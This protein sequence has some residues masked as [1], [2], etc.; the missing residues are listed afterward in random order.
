[1]SVSQQLSDKLS[2]R[3]PDLIVVVGYRKPGI[4]KVSMRWS[5][6]IRKITLGAIGKIPGATGGGHEHATGAQI[7][8]DHF[9]EF[10]EFMIEA[11]K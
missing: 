11:S 1:M 4:I 3:H 2:Y 6:D 5:G 9:D 10:K 8:D 7:P